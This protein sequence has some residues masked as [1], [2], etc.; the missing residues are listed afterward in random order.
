VVLVHTVSADVKFAALPRQF[1]FKVFKL[2][3]SE[4][5]GLSV[6]A[7]TMNS[8]AQN[9]ALGVLFGGD[10]VLSTE[11]RCGVVTPC[12]VA[13]EYQLS[14]GPCCSHLQDL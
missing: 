1:K 7:R 11:L 4:V 3:K 6:V 13:V 9:I 12:S 14:G 5:L 8:K 2:L 10:K